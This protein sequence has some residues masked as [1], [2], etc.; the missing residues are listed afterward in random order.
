MKCP[1]AIEPHQIQGLDNINILPVVQWL[2]KRAIETR[3]LEGDKIRK[4]A[5]KQYDKDHETDDQKDDNAG[6]AQAGC[7][8]K[9]LY[10]PKDVN[11]V[12]E[13]QVDS[14]LLEYGQRR[15][16]AHDQPDKLT[17]RGRCYI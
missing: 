4:F 17:K 8:P 3:Q 11:I 10:K 7:K 14:T 1:Y 16:R 6:I 13:D 12:V 15:A 9:R 2:V 5:V